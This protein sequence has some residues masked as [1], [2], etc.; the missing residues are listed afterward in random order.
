LFLELSF[1]GKK[2]HIKAMGIKDFGQLYKAN[3]S[4]LTELFSKHGIDGHLKNVIGV[5]AS[6]LMIRD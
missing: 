1:E 4:T 3:S 6:V 2:V 5:D